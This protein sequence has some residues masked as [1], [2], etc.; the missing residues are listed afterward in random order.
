VRVVA[1]FDE[2]VVVGN[3]EGCVDCVGLE[4]EVGVSDWLDF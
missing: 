4:S 2:A 3:A 1:D